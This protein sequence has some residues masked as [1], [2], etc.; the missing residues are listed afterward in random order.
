MPCA[1]ERRSKKEKKKVP[2][3]RTTKTAENATSIR[4]IKKPQAKNYVNSLCAISWPVG[5][6]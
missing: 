3:I 4:P 2:A 5:K 1:G 6:G